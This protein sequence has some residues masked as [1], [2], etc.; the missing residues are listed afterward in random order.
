MSLKTEFPKTIPEETRQVVE[1]LLSE[2]NVYRRIGQEIEQM[3]DEGVLAEMYDEEGRPA[4]N[5]IVLTLVTVFQFLG[6]L[7]D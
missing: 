4:I 1:P 3:L 6:K 7:P 2:D 5:P